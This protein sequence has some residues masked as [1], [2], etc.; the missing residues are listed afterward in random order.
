[1][2]KTRSEKSGF[3]LFTFRPLSWCVRLLLP[4]F[5]LPCTHIFSNFFYL[6]L[7][8]LQGNVII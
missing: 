2:M 6:R 1:M 3:F 7:M 4:F 8:T 5:K